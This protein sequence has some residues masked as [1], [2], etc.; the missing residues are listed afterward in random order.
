MCSSDLYR[1]PQPINW[2]HNLKLLMDA[3]E[4][5]ARRWAKREEVENDALSEWIKTVRSFICSRINKLKGS[6]NCKPHSVLQDPTARKC[7]LDLHEKFVIVP[8]DKAANNVTFICKH[9]YYQCLFEELGIGKTQGNPTYTP[10]SFSKTDVI[11][12][13][14]S[15]LNSYG[16]STDEKELH[17][18]LLYWTP[19]LHKCPYK[20][21]YI[22]GSAVCSTKPLSVLLTKLL[23]EVKTGL[24]NYCETAYSHSGINQM[25]ILKNSKELIDNL[26][27]RSFSTVNSIKT[28]D[29][30]T[31]YTNIP[32]SKLKE[33]LKNLVMQCFFYKSGKRRYTYLVNSFKSTYFVKEHTDSDKKYTETDIIGMLEFLIDN[34]FVE[35]GGQIFQQ[36][37]GIPMGTNCAPLLADL[38]LYSYEA[39]FIQM[40][41]R[42]GQKKLASSF[43]FTYRYIDDVL[44]L[45]NSNFSDYLHCIYPKELEIKETTETNKSATYLD[46]HLE[47]G[48]NGTL[49]SKLYDKRDDFDFPIVNF[50]FLCGNIPASPAY[51]VFVSQL[52]R[53]ARACSSYQDFKTRA[54]Q[55]A[56]KLLRQGYLKIRLQSSFKKFYGRHHILVDQYGLSVTQMVVD[57][58][59]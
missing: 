32:H 44:S 47:I 9:Y 8:A 56:D 14:R 48:P 49:H 55:L 40:L 42:Q 50:P 20:Q 15:V 54:K 11:A 16:I 29:F 4:A 28:F 27:S 45:N 23:S 38:F 36:T 37:I 30:A 7:L 22:A 21:R 26:K 57:I 24:Q 10:V 41:Q 12:N 1:E 6:M 19:K 59:N 18:P 46:L 58:I 2:K 53:Y 51:G 31:L 5:Y 13:H 3:V 43:N 33:R 25:W 17:L 35:F 39:E 34:I 52:V